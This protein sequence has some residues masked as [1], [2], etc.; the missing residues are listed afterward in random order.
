[1]E[2]THGS[3]VRAPAITWI[4]VLL[5]GLLAAK[6]AVAAG[7]PSA[8]ILDDFETPKALALFNGEDGAQVNLAEEHATSG[9]KCM[10]VA[11][12]VGTN[13]AGP[14]MEALPVTDW[15]GYETFLVDVYNPQ[16]TTVNI[17]QK[18]KGGDRQ[19]T[20]SF[21]IPPQ[22]SYTIKVSIHDLADRIDV[23]HI[24]YLKYF[25]GDA[26]NGAKDFTLYFDNMR[27]ESNS[28]ASAGAKTNAAPVEKAEARG[29]DAEW[30]ADDPRWKVSPDGLYRVKFETS[31]NKIFSDASRNV[32]DKR[33]IKAFRLELAQNEYA[34]FQVVVQTKSALK[35]VRLTW[36]DLVENAGDQ[37]RVI[38]RTNVTVN[39]VGYVQIKKPY[40]RPF[41]GSSE[42]G[43][44]PDPLLEEQAVDVKSG[45]VQPFWVTVRTPKNVRAGDYRLSLTVA[46]DGAADTVLQ[47]SVHVWNFVLPDESHLETVFEIT[48]K[49][50]RREHKLA[51]GSAEAYAMLDMYYHDMLAHR[52]SPANNLADI[53]DNQPK[54]LG[55]KDGVAS[56]DF[57]GFDAAIEKYLA[58][59]Q[60]AFLFPVDI[61]Q[62]KEATIACCRA[63]GKHLES[64]G[65][66][67]YFYTWLVDE[68][69]DK[70][71]E[72]GWVHEGH[73]G[74]RNMVDVH[75]GPD[76]KY[77]Q[78]DI[79]CPHIED[80]YGAF[81]E[82]IEWARKNGK[83]LWV[84]TSGNAESFYPCMNMDL[85]NVD[86]RITVWYCWKVGATGYMYWSINQWPKGSP[87]TETFTFPRQN[88]NG[89]M[90]YPGKHGPVHTIRL[91]T[92]RDGM[93][94]YEYFYLL[95]SL[96]AKSKDGAKAMELL[97]WNISD[98]DF[99]DFYCRDASIDNL[100]ATR[101]KIAAAIETLQASSV[102]GK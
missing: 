62:G 66:L 59:H 25:P 90:Y 57:S 31:L 18:L 34:P 9:A 71:T 3:A 41:Y 22:Q 96:A 74:I 13:F 95:R 56:Y 42:L 72:R 101:A 33:E 4:V 97:K 38:S 68:A 28:A 58:L 60:N 102:S 87:W 48:P 32:F 82:K 91:E 69:Y 67:K 85:P 70:E 64:K 77:P 17:S 30:R 84:Y 83:T 92:F 46:A 50:I 86:P 11:F 94:D 75:G 26:N 44:W 27:L 79:W 24:K 2:Q 61:L 53:P 35:N 89:S 37:Q 36:G 63:I 78:T 51:A 43:F 39:P 99:M 23:T 10:K 19:V 20:Q 40:Y 14:L 65:W 88:G 1:M 8:V 98:K 93:E 6:P 81:P 55:I 12:P 5:V 80:G 49:Y 76:P 73:P 52:M 16:D 54:L 7:K 100:G 47:A 15:S 29:A 45:D 21:K